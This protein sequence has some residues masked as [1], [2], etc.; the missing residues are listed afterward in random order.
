MLLL[1]PCSVLSMYKAHDIP[2]T[3]KF[4][5]SFVCQERPSNVTSYLKLSLPHI[6]DFQIVNDNGCLQ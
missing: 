1:I 4:L 6:S 5:L 2:H 3:C